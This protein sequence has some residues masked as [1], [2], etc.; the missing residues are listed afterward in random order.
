MKQGIKQSIRTL[1]SSIVFWTLA[2]AFFSVFRFLG[3]QEEVGLLPKGGDE[4]KS[5]LEYLSVLSTLG[6]GLGL[7]YGLL[8]L[9]FEKIVSQRLTLGIRLFL[10]TTFYFLVTVLVVSLVINTAALIFDLKFSIELGWW[11]DDKRFWAV[12]IFIIIMSFVYSFIQIAGNKFG[13]G[14]F[15]KMLLGR[16][17]K[18][19]EEKRIFMFIDLKSS[20]TIAEELGH[21]NY[22]QLVQDCFYDLNEVV[23]K[24][25]GEIYQYVGDEAVISWNFTKGLANNNCIDLYF[26]LTTLL[27]EKEAFYRNKYGLIPEFKA[28]VHGGT[29]MVAEVGTIKK[30]LAYHGD[31]IN[32][33][34]RIQSLCNEYKQVLII[35]ESLFKQL[36]RIE[37]Y[38]ISFL[39]TPVLKGKRNKVNLLGVKRNTHC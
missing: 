16:Y 39:E 6:L 24:Y 26:A 32:T 36:N 13:R 37:K 22:S 2:L 9:F 28:G 8:D 23:A 10:K 38:E 14:V 3:I 34:A 5:M 18:P 17:K 21:F 11:R 1:L 31:V 27:Q 33:T 29:L 20:T 19:K 15:L 7:L 35:S 4:S 12:L 25:D 30:E